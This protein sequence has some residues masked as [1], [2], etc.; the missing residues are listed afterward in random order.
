[1]T[2]QQT[3]EWA[4]HPASSP[5]LSLTRSEMLPFGNASF[6]ETNVLFILTSGYKY[7]V[8]YPLL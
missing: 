6:L 8:S 3:Q 5:S 7:E 1:M 4:H 2:P